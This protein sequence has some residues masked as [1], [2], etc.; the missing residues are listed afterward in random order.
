MSE[1]EIPEQIAQGLAQLIRMTCNANNGY[2]WHS[3]IT[4]GDYNYKIT[5]TLQDVDPVKEA[6]ISSIIIIRED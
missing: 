6:R 2:L 3:T 1:V 4:M 5:I